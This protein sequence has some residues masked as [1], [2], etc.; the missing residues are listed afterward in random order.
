MGGDGRGIGVVEVVGPTLSKS[1]LL[2]VTTSA[3]RS[4]ENPWLRTNAST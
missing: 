4:E 3:N 2:P 1:A